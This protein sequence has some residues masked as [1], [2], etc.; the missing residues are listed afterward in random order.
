MLRFFFKVLFL[1]YVT[2]RV[3]GKWPK[4][5]PKEREIAISLFPLETFFLQTLVCAIIAINLPLRKRA[6]THRLRRLVFWTAFFAVI[7]YGWTFLPWCMLCGVA[8][9]TRQYFMC[10]KSEHTECVTRGF[11][12]YVSTRFFLLSSERKRKEMKNFIKSNFK[13]KYK[14]LLK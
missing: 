11:S 14:N 12:W 10:P 5:R 1:F 6:L 2:F 4:G 9:A 8:G 13:E 7:V 3:A